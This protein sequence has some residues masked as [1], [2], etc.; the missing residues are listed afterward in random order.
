MVWY[1]NNNGYNKL[2]TEPRTERINA[3]NRPCKYKGWSNGTGWTV[4]CPVLGSK[5]IFKA[6]IEMPNGSSLFGGISL[7]NLAVS[8]KNNGPRTQKNKTIVTNTY[9]LRKM[10]HLS[11]TY[12]PPAQY[13]STTKSPHSGFKFR[14]TTCTQMNETTKDKNIASITHRCAGRVFEKSFSEKT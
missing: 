7:S 2:T 11:W 6:K 13:K 9:T 3:T 5:Q 8:Q 10:Q 1:I 14:L 12:C 4:G